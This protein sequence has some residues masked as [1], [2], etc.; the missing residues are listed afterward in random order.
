MRLDGII[1]DLDGTLGDTLPICYAAFRASLLQFVGRHYSDAEICALF[2]PSEEGVFQNVAPAQAEA[3]LEMYLQAYEREHASCTAPFPGVD[4]LLAWL[5]EH[6]V[7][8]AIVTGKG[9]RSAAISL[10]R[11]G[12]SSYFDLVEAGS[13]EGAVKPAAIRAVL[14]AWNADPARVAY[15][16]DAPSD[17]DAARQVGTLAIAAAWAPA[18][19]ATASELRARH[20]D[21][22]FTTVDAFV[23]WLD[24][25]TAPSDDEVEPAGN[26][27]NQREKR[28]P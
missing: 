2:G 17:I 21:A 20:P 19:L 14:N 26:V 7:K 12:L 13:P 22:T 8:Q 10:R 11:L 16:G 25:Q 24:E 9:P 3:A 1:F 27:A 23:A 28:V 4:R 15:V 6:G 5:R 18:A